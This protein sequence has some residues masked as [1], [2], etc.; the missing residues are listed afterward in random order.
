MPGEAPGQHPRLDA[1]APCRRPLRG[2]AG[3]WSGA[4]NEWRLLRSTA[5]SRQG[6]PICS[7]FHCR[8]Y[9]FL[10]RILL[11]WWFFFLKIKGL[12][13]AP[14]EVTR[15]KVR[16]VRE[17]AKTARSPGESREHPTEQT[18]S[19]TPR[20]TRHVHL[21]TVSTSSNVPWYL[22]LPRKLRRE[23][24]D[25]ASSPQPVPA[26][27][28]GGQTFLIFLMSLSSSLGALLC[29]DWMRSWSLSREAICGHRDSVSG[30]RRDRPPRAGTCSGCPADVSI[31]LT[32]SSVGHQ[33][34]AKRRRV[35]H[36]SGAGALPAWRVPPGLETSPGAKR[37]LH[38]WER[39]HVP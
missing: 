33:Q 36:P 21:R 16:F 28:P 29:T 38:R 15:K 31:G 26:G 37:R 13:T 6:Q 9:C 2:A 23:R 32:L 17:L 12:T 34:R 5:C 1:L 39:L 3:C 24:K 20:F 8:G 30:A 7:R 35:P 4:C 25:R 18:A 27:P 19:R 14:G 11:G 10:R 22:Q